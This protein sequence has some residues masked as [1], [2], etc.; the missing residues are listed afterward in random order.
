MGP[1]HLQGFTTGCTD[2]NYPSYLGLM[3]GDY[4]VGCGLL[5][6]LCVRMASVMGAILH[7]EL[8]YCSGLDFR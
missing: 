8:Y 4:S 7:V 6:G 1:S 5:F 2:G 3:S